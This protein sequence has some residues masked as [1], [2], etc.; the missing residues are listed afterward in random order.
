MGV[1][2]HTCAQPLFH[3]HTL[4]IKW[5][6]CIHLRQTKRQHNQTKRGCSN[7]AFKSF[8]TRQEL[9]QQAVVDLWSQHFREVPEERLGKAKTAFPKTFA[10]PTH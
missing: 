7:S 4:K 6:G 1:S 8:S 10:H 2:A 9:Q 3:F 5:L